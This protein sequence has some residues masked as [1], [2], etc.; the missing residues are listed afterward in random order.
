VVGPVQEIVQ[1]RRQLDPVL[2]KL[3]ETLELLA[4]LVFG[5]KE[6]SVPAFLVA[7]AFAVV[8]ALQH[9]VEHPSLG[10]P[11]GVGKVWPFVETLEASQACLSCS[12]LLL[13]L[14]VFWV[15]SVVVFPGNVSSRG[16]WYW[17]PA[18]SGG[19]APLPPQVG[20][21][22]PARDYRVLLNC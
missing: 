3:R 9:L 16:N 19:T 7:V 1:P 2:C 21:V 12:A 5:F 11:L 8:Y 15:C 6:P 10:S 14:S 13:L 18:P 4:N 22:L 20:R 17:L